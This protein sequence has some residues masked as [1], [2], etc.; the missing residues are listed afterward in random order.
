MKNV[1]PQRLLR[2]RGYRETPLLLTQSLIMAWKQNLQHVVGILRRTREGEKE[3]KEVL[4][5]PNQLAMCVG[6]R[7]INRLFVVRHFLGLTVTF[8]PQRGS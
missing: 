6:P 8:S 4:R 2:L 7:D 3:Q 5:E 1:G